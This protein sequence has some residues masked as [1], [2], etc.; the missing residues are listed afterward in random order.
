MKQIGRCFTIFI[1]PDAQKRQTPANKEK[2]FGLE[3]RGKVVKLLM[4]TFAL[5]IFVIDFTASILL[6]CATCSRLFTCL[7]QNEYKNQR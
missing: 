4:M 2:I 6:L 1:I 5:V 3:K 7:V